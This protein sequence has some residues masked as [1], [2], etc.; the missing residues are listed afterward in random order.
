MK[1]LNWK[2]EIEE[3]PAASDSVNF[4]VGS[5]ERRATLQDVSAQCDDENRGLGGGG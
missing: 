3:E 5:S 2:K 1:L 4:T